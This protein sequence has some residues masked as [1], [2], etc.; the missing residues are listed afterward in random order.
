MLKK[1][2]IF[3]VGLHKGEDTR[4]YLQKGFNVVAFEANPWLIEQCRQ[5]FSRQIDDGQLILVEGAVTDTI[6]A[7]NNQKSIKFYRNLDDSAWGTVCENW[8]H[9]NEKL[10]TRNEVIEVPVIDF[11]KCLEQYGIPY[12]LKI[13]IEGMDTVCLK[14]L[15][16]IEGRPSYISIESEKLSFEKLVAELDLFNSLGY[17]RFKAVQQSGISRRKEPVPAREGNQTAYQFEEGASGLFGKD[18]AGQWKNYDQILAEYKKIFYLYDHFG[19]FGK[20][21]RKI[22]G[23]IFRE[24]ASTLLQKPIP[25]WYDTHARHKSVKDDYE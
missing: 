25:G 4:F 6:P 10:R 18:L 8:A 19:D 15:Q 20:W 11:S 13:D 21:R 12:Y 5:R 22:L 3:D 23:R 17:T 16:K 14:S 1:K 7:D 24:V 9:R 2:L